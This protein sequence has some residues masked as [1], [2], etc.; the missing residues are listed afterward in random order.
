MIRHAYGSNNHPDPQTFLQL[1]RL[2]STYSLIKPPKG[3]SIAG[4]EMLS[5]LLSNPMAETPR[6]GDIVADTESILQTLFV[7]I[8]ENNYCLH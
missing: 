7:Y 1:Y 3:S 2:L 6:Q 5:A 4:S 8:N